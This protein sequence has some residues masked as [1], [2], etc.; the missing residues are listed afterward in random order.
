M[1]ILP[2]VE[3]TRATTLAPF[4]RSLRPLVAPLRNQSKQTTPLEQTPTLG[5][6]VPLV[7]EQTFHP[8]ARSTPS[9]P[10]NPHRR[11]YLGNHCFITVGGL[12]RRE[13][14]PQRTASPFAQQ[15]QFTR[16]PTSTASQALRG[17]RCLGRPPFLGAPAACGCAF[18]VVLSRLPSF[19]SNRPA[20]S[21]CACNRCRTWFHTP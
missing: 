5:I 15:M 20:L 11:Q 14:Q 19:Q 12:S 2:L 18:I 6:T 10:R 9:Q 3:I 1:V 17:L 16:Q 7:T 13:S 21:S 4:L 8:L